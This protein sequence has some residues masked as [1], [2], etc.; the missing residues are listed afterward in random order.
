MDQENLPVPSGQP[1]HEL[2]PV[3]PLSPGGRFAFADTDPGDTTESGAAILKRLVGAVLYYKWL[4]LGITA[5]GCVAA[6]LVSRTLE[7]TYTAEARL[8]ISVTDRVSERQ[9]PIQS[10]ELL[11]GAAWV[12]LIR[13]YT[14]LDPVV[15][16]HRLYLRYRASDRD[17]LG[18]L[19]TDSVFMPGSYIA[20]VDP[21]GSTVELREERRGVLERVDVGEPI[22]RDIGLIWTPA[23]DRLTPDRQIIFE[24]EHP[25]AT[26]RYVMDAMTPRLVGDNFLMLQY[27]HNNPE[28]AATVLNSFTT[29]YVELAAELKRAKL[30]EFRDILEQQLTYSEENLRRAELALESFRIQTITLPSDPATPVNPG[31]EATRDPALASY[32]QLS[33]D[34]EA[35]Q[36]DRS[37]IARLLATVGSEP[38]SVDALTVIP[39][40]AES[41]E[42]MQALTELTESRAE[43]R[44]LSRQYTEE[45]PLVRRATERVDN[46]QYT[47]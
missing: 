36:R 9:G 1:E 4:V 15:S 6:F 43:L 18:N 33:I 44:A 34:R 38:L 26:A 11:Q 20:A 8:W 40:V 24:L 2:A 7:M 23:A 47:V 27:E 41:P 46:I 10:P 31:I 3:Q 29:K 16:E 35:L 21:S 45:H 25:R 12:E 37:A 14:V 5:L 13:S 42:L 22:G 28:L 17:V 30:E 32:F 39:T 19:S